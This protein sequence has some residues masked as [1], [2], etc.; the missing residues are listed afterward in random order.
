MVK[1][2][3]FT[4]IGGVLLILLAALVF[5]GMKGCET[6]TS[7]S[8]R[9]VFTTEYNGAES[10]GPINVSL[11]FSSR[12]ELNKPVELTFDVTSAIDVRNAETKFVLPKALQLVQGTVTQRVHLRPNES[13]RFS[14]M[15]QVTEEIW[16]EEVKAIVSWT[17]NGKTFTR[18]GALLISVWN[19]GSS[20]TKIAH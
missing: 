8:E 1:M 17:A 14:V 5:A 16:D 11:S 9:D 20:V 2:P 18:T 7:I 19:G 6:P 4:I 15:V 10:P 13:H 12:P 3:F